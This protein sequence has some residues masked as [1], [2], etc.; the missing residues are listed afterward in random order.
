MNRAEI[1]NANEPLKVTSTSMPTTPPDGAR[2]RTAYAGVCHSD[3]HLI[4]DSGE[5]MLLRSDGEFLSAVNGL[6]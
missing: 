6:Q 1:T 3:I 2:L 4:Q 5:Y